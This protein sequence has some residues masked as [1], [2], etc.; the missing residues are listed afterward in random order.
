MI[1]EETIAEIR[2]RIDLVDFIGQYVKL[3]KVGASH[4]GLCPFH[5][6]KTPSFYVHRERRFYHCFGCQAS[7][8]A[9]GFLRQLEGLS[10]PEAV[11]QLA[12]RVG[13]ELPSLDP[14]EQAEQQRHKQRSARLDAAMEAATAFFVEQ[15]TVHP[16]GHVA[17]AEYERR[18]ITTATAERFRLGYA[19]D[20]WDALGAALR[21]R[22]VAD[23]DAEAVGLI[24]RRRSG[25]GYYDRFRH[26][27]MF[28]VADV[29]GR[30]VA[31]SGRLLP[32]ADPHGDAAPRDRAPKYINSPESPIYHKGSVL[33]G[34]HQGRVAVR[35]EGWSLVCEGNFDLL[36]L[37]QAGFENAVA[38]LGTALTEAHARLLRR[39]GE[40]A[41][42]LFDGDAAGRKAAR[43]AY[44]LLAA[45]GV[46][47]S[48]AALPNGHDPDSFLRER[49]PEVLHALVDA[50][51]GIVV[52]LIDEAVAS[53][54]GD[55]HAKA[56]AIAGLGPVLASVDNPVE[57]PIYIER[58]GR[59][60][61]VRD[62]HSVRRQLR[63]GLAPR[64]R[65][66][67]PAAAEQK[68]NDPG[69]V[70]RADPPKLEGELF[71]L[72]LHHPG[73]FATEEANNLRDL[74]T[75]RDLQ[76]MFDSASRMVEDRG[77]ID[78]PGL[79]SEC[80]DSPALGW[81]EE[82]LVVQ[83]HG[84]EEAKDVLADGVLRLALQNIERE[85]RRLHGAIV[86]ARRQGDEDRARSLTRRQVALAR[87]ANRLHQRNSKR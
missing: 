44:P 50:A 47:A 84:A 56:E 82:R 61:G 13:V 65:R 20:A 63:R 69:R 42:L 53:A 35:R 58:I 26:R 86:D 48:V 46:G 19:P 12:E 27:L 39:Y 17:R 74:L 34:L 22:G 16:L 79:L 32:P 83:Q 49:G 57:V 87:S 70:R 10:F 66:R 23:R 21:A 60:F 80:G 85:L 37:H 77:A 81:L 7:G 30:V 14:R 40:R 29:H 62:L 1:P 38:P 2:E 8:D 25:S 73:L 78:G 5:S 9:I 24:A 15:L 6:E 59:R 64:D 4:R 72:L 67:K 3:K 28:P 11:A 36:A 18:G 52:Y 55:A 45:A 51:P 43:A 68:P 54:A 33:F 71:A 41:V 31:F 76:A 75:S